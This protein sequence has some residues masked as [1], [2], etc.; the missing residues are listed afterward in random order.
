MG[1]ILFIIFAFA[2][3][4]GARWYTNRPPAR[5]PAAPAQ[6]DANR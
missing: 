2:V 5:P 4:V 1:I 3:T 6:S